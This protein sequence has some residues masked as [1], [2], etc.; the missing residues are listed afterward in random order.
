MDGFECIEEDL[1]LNAEVNREPM[2]LVQD[3]GDVVR[4]WGSGDDSCCRVL[5]QL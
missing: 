2:K 1:E 5:D 3:R 4:G